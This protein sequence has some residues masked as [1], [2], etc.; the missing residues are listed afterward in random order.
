M[1]KRVMENMC[2]LGFVAAEWLGMNL[3]SGIIG[4]EGLDT[5]MESGCHRSER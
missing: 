4:H 3:Y 5:E 1:Y 2:R